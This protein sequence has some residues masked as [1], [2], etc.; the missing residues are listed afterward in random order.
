MVPEP[1]RQKVT[2]AW[3]T[4]P[5]CSLFCVEARLSA[6]QAE[7]APQDVL[8]GPSEASLKFGN[9]YRNPGEAKL[10]I[11]QQNVLV[12]HGKSALELR[13]DR[14][15]GQPGR[16][17]QVCNWLTWFLC[18]VSPGFLRLGMPVAPGLGASS[19]PVSV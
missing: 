10:E 17:S 1:H 19:G 16:M 13:R 11:W 4:C 8:F 2:E 6:E 18:V 9:F 15:L 14:E 5:T 3:Q 12:P 7:S